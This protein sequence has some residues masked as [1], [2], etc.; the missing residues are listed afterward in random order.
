MSERAAYERGRFD[1]GLDAYQE[2]E[3]VAAAEAEER[4][5]ET[6]ARPDAVR[7]DSTFGELRVGDYMTAEGPGGRW[8]KVVELGAFEAKRPGDVVVTFEIP[9]PVT[10]SGERRWIIERPPGTP[11]VVD[12]SLRTMTTNHGLNRQAGARP[13]RLIDVSKHVDAL[14]PGPDGYVDMDVYN[15]SAPWSGERPAP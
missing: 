9:E 8:V 2:R 5:H 12:G 11:V 3:R 4:S 14:R 10:V 7:L 15:R 13:D 1:A 6:A